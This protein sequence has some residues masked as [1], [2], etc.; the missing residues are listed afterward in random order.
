MKK[1]EILQF[2]QKMIAFYSLEILYPKHQ[3]EIKDSEKEFIVD[4]KIDLKD[5]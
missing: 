5:E 2:I 4:L 3:L 1:K